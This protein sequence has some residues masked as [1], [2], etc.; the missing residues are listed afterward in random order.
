MIRIDLNADI[1]ESFNYFKVGNDTEVMKYI[2]SCN[3]ACGFHS[4]DPLTIEKTIDLALENSVSIGAHPSF[5]DMQGFGRRYMKMDNEELESTVRYQLYAL[6]GLVEQHGGKMKHVK[7]HGA[8]YNT[9]Y[10]EEEVAEAIMKAIRSVDD[11]LILVGPA[12]RGYEKWVTE[13]GLKSASE[14]FADRNYNDDLSLV[15]RLKTNA[16]ITDV[17]QRI[18]HI[19]SMVI[20]HEVRTIE[21][22]YKP[23]RADTICIHG[24]HPLAL[25]T[26]QN[27]RSAIE[28][29]GIE[30]RAFTCE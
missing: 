23:I 1:G 2:T 20:D 27:L 29:W 19:K 13:F 7:P 4:G 10:Q 14:I 26:A 9:A 25:Q 28:E 16:M 21:G 24:D 8:L 11:Q 3:I 17:Q 30:V 22:S 5:P 12:G 18:E 15:N 6:K